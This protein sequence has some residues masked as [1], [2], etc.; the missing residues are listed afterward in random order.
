MTQPAQIRPIASAPSVTARQTS[1]SSA[2]HEHVVQ[3]YE[4]DHFLVATVADYIA[5]GLLRGEPVV[6]IA[7]PM[8]RDAFAAR[9]RDRGVD[10]EAV[11]RE[12]RLTMLDARDMLAGF[13]LGSTP[14][15]KR[16]KGV[17]GGLIEGILGGGGQSSVRA[18]GEMVD[19]LWRDGNTDGAI[20]L[21]ELWN[22]LAATCSF[23]LLCAYN[24]GNFYKEAHAN[25]F[26][27]VC[28]RHSRVIPTERYMQGDDSARLLE[29]TLLQQRAKALE[30]EI[31]H[32]RELE[33]RLRETITARRD[34]EEALRES[35][36]RER[37]ARFEAEA[38]NA[39][40][41]EFLAAMSHELRTPLNAIAGHIELVEMGVHGPLSDA[42]RDALHRA[43]RS[44][45]H[46][47]ALITNVL[48]LARI[49]AGHVDYELAEVA[50]S[51][52]VAEV[53]STVEPLLSTRRLTLEVAES[54]VGPLIAR[55][56]NEKVY[57]IVL[58]LMTNAIKFTPVGGIITIACA[59][60][61]EADGMVC[62]HVRDTGIGIPASKLQ[63]IFDPFVQLGVAT[64]SARDGIGLGLA[65]SRDL[66]RGMSG[67]L[68]VKSAVGQG[69]TFTLRLPRAD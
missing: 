60:C 20:Q 40:K 24:M 23:T 26:H 15:A 67:E 58:N 53:S 66:A 12:G 39:A 14:D 49:E 2:A 46:L 42:Q 3:F 6:I 62:V 68:A 59:P 38:A 44:Q 64:S 10:A 25:Q 21:E 35:L 11:K 28:R 29:I 61:T 17:V 4:S 51:S 16:F 63:R 54:E 48:N 33:N 31:E 13:M 19:V 5:D 36:H 69:S 52:V 43:Q 18:Y 22:D 1:G 34:A 50:L 9:L 65:I 56:D 47:L 8:H 41:S 45:R 30:S 57:Q 32:R 27:E 37:A 55:A 7:T